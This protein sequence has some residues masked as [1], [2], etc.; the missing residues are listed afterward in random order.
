MG[1]LGSRAGRT[2]R[3]RP[4]NRAKRIRTGDR[5]P[6]SP[7]PTPRPLGRT[8]PRAS[9]PG[10]PRGRSDGR[11]GA[12]ALSR[13]PA[14]PVAIPHRLPPAPAS[15]CPF[16]DE[17]LS[18]VCIDPPVPLLVRIGQRA[19]GD[20]STNAE[21]VQTFGNGTRAGLDIAQAVAILRSCNGHGQE[22][23][24]PGEPPNAMISSVAPDAAID[25]E[26]R[27]VGH[28]LREDRAPEVHRR[29]PSRVDDRM[30]RPKR[31]LKSA[32]PNH[33]CK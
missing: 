21:V 19:A 14:P 25:C 13:S 18:E 4:P 1:P 29:L 28:R 26:A 9:P 15:P 2:E 20:G 31:E 16:V 3:H 23:I 8:L 6:S 5:E 7:E 12:I 27:A 22:L 24:P 10:R 11:A 30:E 17:T 32:R 33:S